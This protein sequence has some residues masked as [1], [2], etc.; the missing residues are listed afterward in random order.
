LD[1][2]GLTEVPI[3]IDPFFFKVGGIEERIRLLKDIYELSIDPLALLL[4]GDVYQRLV[5]KW[6]PHQPKVAEIEAA[7]NG[8]T[9]NEKAVALAKARTVGTRARLVEQALSESI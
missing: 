2:D 1:L 8:M 3:S 7:L 6:N 9:S 5:E 4:P